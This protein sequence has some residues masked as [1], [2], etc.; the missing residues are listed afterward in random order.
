MSST[1]PKSGDSS[2]PLTIVGIGASAGGLAALKTFF[3][4]VPED[5]GLAFV[6]VVHLSPDG[7]SHLADILQP[8]AK[9]PVQQVTETVPIE[10]NHVYIIPP[11]RNLE[12]IDTDLRLSELEEARRDRAPIDHFLRT[13]AAVHDGNSVGVILSGRA[14]TEP[15]VSGRLREPGALPWFKTPTRPSTTGCPRAPSPPAGSTRCC[16]WPKSPPTSSATCAHPTPD[17]RG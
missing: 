12:T 10:A 5:S 14:P 9:I 6:V 3:A 15:W 1:P 4:H 7:E 11:G 13:L 17:I 2:S 8:K 16:R